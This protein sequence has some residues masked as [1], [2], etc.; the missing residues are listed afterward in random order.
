MLGNRSNKCG[1]A[2]AH[3]VYGIQNPD[4]FALDFLILKKTLEEF[5]VIKYHQDRARRPTTIAMEALIHANENPG[6]I[7]WMNRIHTVYSPRAALA[8]D[9]PSGLA[10][11]VRRPTTQSCYRTRTS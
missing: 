3:S 1:L 10:E 4:P 8:L 9:V 2:A 7:V 5:T 11:C 6:G